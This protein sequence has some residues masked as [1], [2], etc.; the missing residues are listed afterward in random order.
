MKKAIDSHKQATQS[1]QLNLFTNPTAAPANLPKDCSWHTVTLAGQPLGY[2]LRRSRRKSVGLVVRDSGLLIQAPT[3][4]TQQQIDEVIV[5]K[6][7]WIHEKLRK[8][9]QRLEQIT[10]QAS[11]W[12]DGG[13]IPY[14]GKRI[15]LQL[16]GSRSARY[17]GNLLAPTEDDHLYLPLP[18]DAD[19]ER[20]RERAQ[21]W[22][23]T[24]ARKVFEDRLKHYLELSGEVMNGWSLSSAQGRWGSCTSSRHI[25]LNWR[26]I[27]F[28]IP[29]IDYVVAHEVAHLRHMNHSAA[30]W[31]EV[32]HLYPNSGRA[33]D[34]LAQ[35]TPQTQPLF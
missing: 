12:R 25:R 5:Q 9:D 6:A 22:L 34:I 2:A 35:H 10:Q 27:H 1:G 26:L 14:L 15:H 28:S 31:R 4:A 16:D 18:L 20:I 21:A 17:E 33:R 29:L 3:W 32:D 8:R 30:F 11:Q 13:H 19:A 7:R 24:R 23:Q